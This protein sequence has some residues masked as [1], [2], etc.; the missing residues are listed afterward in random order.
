MIEDAW[1]KV[2]GLDAVGGVEVVRLHWHSPNAAKSFSLQAYGPA[3]GAS[4]G[5]TD[6]ALWTS[7]RSYGVALTADWATVTHNP[8]DTDNAARGVQLCGVRDRVDTLQGGCV[9]LCLCAMCE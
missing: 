1:L 3:S 7:K 6:T 5:S 9:C 4:W 8:L 2:D